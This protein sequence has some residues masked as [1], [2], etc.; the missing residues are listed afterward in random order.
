MP[1]QLSYLPL[2]LPVTTAIAAPAAGA[3]PGVSLVVSP[4]GASAVAVGHNRRVVEQAIR[5]EQFLAQQ[6]LSV[7]TDWSV[8]IVVDWLFEFAYVA[9]QFF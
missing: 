5:A 6:G 7:P 4:L 9:P 1:V 8:H 3:S 2:A